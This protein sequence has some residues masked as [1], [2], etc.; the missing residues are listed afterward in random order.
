MVRHTQSNSV[1]YV[2]GGMTL[3]V[4]A[5]QQ[6]RV[7]VA[8]PT[9]PRPGTA[10]RPEL[11]DPRKN[12]CPD[13]LPRGELRR[14][15]VPAR[16]RREPAL[17]RHGALPMAESTRPGQPR[18]RRRPPLSGQHCSCPPTRGALRGRTRRINPLRGDPQC[19]P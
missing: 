2:R 9:P 7:D 19:L 1:A 11:E 3:G 14:S 17:D 10:R 16:A 15:R 4:G 6:S 8:T 12:Q 5:G 13:P 18:F